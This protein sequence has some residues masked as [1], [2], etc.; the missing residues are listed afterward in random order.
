MQ[1]V[2]KLTEDVQQRRKD[3]EYLKHNL[4]RITVSVFAPSVHPIRPISS[5]QGS[6]TSFNN[7]LLNK[8]AEPAVYPVSVSAYSGTKSYNDAVTT[9]LKPKNSGADSDNFTTGSYRR[10]LLVDL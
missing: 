10:S 2:L 4:N 5:T 8:T 6:S 3:N 7:V 9:G 1:M